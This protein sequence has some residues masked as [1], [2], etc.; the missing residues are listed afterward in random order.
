MAWLNIVRETS[1]LLIAVIIPWQSSSNPPGRYS[2]PLQERWLDWLPTLPQI[3]QE[4]GTLLFGQVQQWWNNKLL[5]PHIIPLW[6]YNLKDPNI[7]VIHI[8]K[9]WVHVTLGVTLSNVTPPNNLL[10]NYYF[11]NPTVELHVLYVLNMHTN[12]HINWMLFTF[13]SINSSFI[14]YFKLQ[15]FEF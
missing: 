11:E 15:K 13:W 12:F 9:G 7:E 4:C 5:L 14:Y 8:N 2:I 10:L 6:Y 1:W 3:P